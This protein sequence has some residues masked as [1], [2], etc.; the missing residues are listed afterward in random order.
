MA[1]FRFKVLGE[2]VRS[3]LLV[4]GLCG[5]L[6]GCSWT[7]SAVDSGGPAPVR[8]VRLRFGESR[9]VATRALAYH[10][11]VVCPKRPATPHAFCVRQV[12]RAPL[13]LHKTSIFGDALG[14]S[15]IKVS[16]GT[17]ETTFK[18]ST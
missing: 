4:A 7:G 10:L 9:T 6:A 3:V 15:S 1:D 11:T 8:H 13:P 17:S 5:V 12:I 2:M 18:C 14:S 16:V